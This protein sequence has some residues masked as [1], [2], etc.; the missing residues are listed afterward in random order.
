M[1]N[2]W[3]AARALFML[4]SEAFAIRQECS[5][6]RSCR[7]LPHWGISGLV[8]FFD[9]ATDEDF[10]ELGD[11]LPGNFADNILR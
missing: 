5:S 8:M 10:R 6:C 2:R 11:N 9:K 3:T 7:L 4:R 1:R